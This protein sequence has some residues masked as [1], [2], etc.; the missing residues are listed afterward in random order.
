MA[1]DGDTVVP[2]DDIYWEN[3]S[4]GTTVTVT[5]SGSSVTVTSSGR[6]VQS[7][8]EGADAAIV[9]D[10]MGDVEVIAS[11]S[12]EGPEPYICQKRGYKCAEQVHS[13]YTPG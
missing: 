1:K 5:Y 10:G 2:G 9:L 12:S 7:H 4:F 11:G 13:V 8:I 3:R 6:S